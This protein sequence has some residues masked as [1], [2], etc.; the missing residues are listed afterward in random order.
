M[1]DNS[2]RGVVDRVF[3]LFV[4]HQWPLSDDIDR[5]STKLNSPNGAISPEAQTQRTPPRRDVGGCRV[6]VT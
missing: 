4:V 1:L 6:A 3:S 5:S 2:L